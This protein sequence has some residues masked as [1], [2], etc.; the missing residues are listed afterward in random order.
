MIW[1]TDVVNKN[2]VSINPDYIVAVYSIIDGEHQGKTA[3]NL[4]NSHVVVEE[5]D[6]DIVSMVENNKK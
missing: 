3:I 4:H 5:S 1:V 6:L 2:K